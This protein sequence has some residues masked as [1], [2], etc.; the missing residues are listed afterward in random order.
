[1]KPGKSL[2]LVRNNQWDPA[3]DPGR[4]Q[5]AERFE[6]SF[7]DPLVNRVEPAILAETSKGQTTLMYQNASPA[8]VQSA[9]ADAPDLLVTGPGGCAYF[10]WPDY[11]KIREIEVRQALGYAFPYREFWRLQGQDLDVTRLPGSSYLLPGTPGRIDDPI[12]S[13]EPWQTN[14][15]KAEALLREAGYE[16]GDYTVSFSYVDPDFVY[17]DTLVEA[18][19][20]AGFRVVP[21]RTTSQ[22]E[23]AAVVADPTAPINLRLGGWCPNWPSG[24]DYLESM[25]TRGGGANYFSYFHVQAVDDEFAR[26]ETLPVTEQPAAIGALEHEIQT[27][28]YPAVVTGYDGRALLH[29]SRI[30]G[31][32]LGAYGAPT[33]KDIYV[34]P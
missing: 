18:L 29:G 14:P 8:A 10:L 11:R 3:T 21:Y 27:R 31:M 20:R 28:Y 12:L 7:T 23:N 16:A 9:R 1:V 15:D 6:F 25:L 22:E 33:Y 24:T 34:M 26:I 19:Q 30:G 32:N 4:H 17:K 5:Y 2:T 13:T